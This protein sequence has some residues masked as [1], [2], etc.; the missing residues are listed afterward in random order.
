MNCV[1]EE[2]GSLEGV[3]QGAGVGANVIVLVDCLVQVQR[4]AVDA[5]LHTSTVGG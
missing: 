2:F 4:L 1:W 5:D 3:Q